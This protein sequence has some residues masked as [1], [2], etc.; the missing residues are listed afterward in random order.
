MDGPGSR[1]GLAGGTGHLN[2]GHRSGK[3]G[4]SC[5]A[6]RYTSAAQ[7]SGGGLLV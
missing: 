5:Q 7:M 6:D 3:E 4:D 2:A 1:V